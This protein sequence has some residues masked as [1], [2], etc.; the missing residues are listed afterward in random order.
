MSPDRQA[1]SSQTM[2]A[3]P[4]M[5]P[6]KTKSPAVQTTPS[7]P[8]CMAIA[9]AS[10]RTAIVDQPMTLRIRSRRRAPGVEAFVM[11]V[12]PWHG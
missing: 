5:I 3:P 6:A 1:I 9:G 11:V 7:A 10:R 2:P 12:D 4:R 8:I